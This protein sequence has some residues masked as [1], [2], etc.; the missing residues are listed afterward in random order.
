[1]W[2]NNSYTLRFNENAF[3]HH[4][5]VILAAGTCSGFLPMAFLRDDSGLVARYECG[6]FRPLSAFRIDR[7]EDALY[8]MEKTLLVLHISPEYL[9]SP[10]RITLRTDTVFYN[11]EQDDLRIAFVP[12]AAGSSKASPTQAGNVSPFQRSLIMYLAQLKQ[13]LRDGHADFISRL[14]KDLCY[15]CRNTSDMLRRIGLLRRELND[16]KSPASLN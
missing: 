12:P 9:L 16:A 13:D 15:N 4:E 3:Y 8:L 7:T 2:E 5:Q 14:A 10:E 11:R 6:G 1:M